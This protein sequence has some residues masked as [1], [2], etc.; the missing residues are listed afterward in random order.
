MRQLKEERDKEALLRRKW[1]EIKTAKKIREQKEKCKQDE[2]IDG[3]SVNDINNMCGCGNDVICS[4]V[5]GSD[6]DDEPTPLS[7]THT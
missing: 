7:H 3:G 4:D 6:G 5:N 1:E 2:C